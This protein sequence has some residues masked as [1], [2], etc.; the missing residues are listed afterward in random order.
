MAEFSV[1][2]GIEKCNPIPGPRSGR[3][4]LKTIPARIKELRGVRKL[5]D[6]NSIAFK[7]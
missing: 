2:V 5:G 6:L 1:I 3:P 7:I 4:M